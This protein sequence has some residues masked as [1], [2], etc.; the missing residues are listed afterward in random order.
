LQ[1]D[2]ELRLED[3]PRE[4]EK[5][6][7]RNYKEGD[8]VQLTRLFNAVYRDYGGF[9]PRTPEFWRWCCLDR[10][11]VEKEGI[12]VVVFKEKIVGYVVVGKSGNIWE[13][14][15]DRAHNSEVLVSSILEKAVEYLTR[16]GVESVTLNLPS[17]DF[18][19]REA[20]GKLGF[21]EVPS[22]KMFL[23]VLDFR[24]FLE[25]LCSVKKERLIGFNE[26]FLISF[27]DAPFWISPRILVR[28]ENG[29]TKI[30]EGNQPHE[31]LIET[32]IG[33]F[34]SILFGTTNPWWA[35]LRFELKIR[36]LRK[37]R[38]VLK[39]F[40]LLRLKDTWFFPS[41]DFG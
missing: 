34:T 22:E 41:S 35:L 17:E 40:S 29:E 3:L 6:I 21:V 36:P 30:E 7:I 23:S 8:E 2:T 18:V 39:W 15:F 10:P 27:K 31:A 28:I 32:D 12:M 19:V 24:Q 1:K 25:L 5:Y 37:I 20:C 38:R 33:T 16:A 11:D 26:N 14:C 4:E 9:V 13:L